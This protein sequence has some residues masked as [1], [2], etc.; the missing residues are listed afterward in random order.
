MQGPGIVPAV[1]RRRARRQAEQ[2]RGR[3]AAAEQGAGLL[4]RFAADGRHAR[5]VPRIP[6]SAEPPAGPTREAVRECVDALPEA[7]RRALRLHDVEG[8]PLAELART[9]G[10]APHAARRRLH[11]ARLALATLLTARLGRPGEA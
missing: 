6:R 8:M 1:G 10:L 4:P 9:L 5:P 3:G 2:D 7:W 11:R